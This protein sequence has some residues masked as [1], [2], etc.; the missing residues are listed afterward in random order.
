MTDDHKV[1]VKTVE[2]PAS[3]HGWMRRAE[4]DTDAVDAW[5]RPDGMLYAASKGE[6]PVIVSLLM[7]PSRYG[8]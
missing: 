5:E 6:H 7:P 2:R 3:A 8:S 4:L 1:V